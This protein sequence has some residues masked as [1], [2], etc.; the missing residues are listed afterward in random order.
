MVALE[1]SLIS[2]AHQKSKEHHRTASDGDTKALSE[3][4]SSSGKLG[5]DKILKTRNRIPPHLQAA[6]A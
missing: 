3:S 5:E 4:G 6:R 2:E 1:L